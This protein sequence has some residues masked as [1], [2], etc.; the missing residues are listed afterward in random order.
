MIFSSKTVREFANELNI[1]LNQVL[2]DLE[3]LEIYT[4]GAEIISHTSLEQLTEI[5]QTRAIRRQEFKDKILKQREDYDAL[6]LKPQNEK[7][8]GLKQQEEIKA[9]ILKQR[10]VAQAKVDEIKPPLQEWQI[11]RLKREEEVKANQLKRQ[12]KRQEEAEAIRVQNQKEEARKLG[13]LLNLESEAILLKNQEKAEAIRLK[14]EAL[15]L[16]LEARNKKVEAIVNFN[17]DNLY[18]IGEKEE[19]DKPNIMTYTLRCCL[20]E[21]DEIYT[22]VWD[23]EEALI[24]WKNANSVYDEHCAIDS[25]SFESLISKN[26]QIKWALLNPSPEM[27]D[28]EISES[29]GIDK[30]MLLSAYGVWPFIKYQFTA[31]GIIDYSLT[32]KLVLEIP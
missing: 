27:T 21:L 8:A 32:K 23:N 10:Q 15:R 12:L 3:T 5:Y 30:M 2:A 11:I 16:E 17:F 18:V 1:P 26:T 19:T 28:Y 9:D 29:M 7:E 4:T 20:N 22:S 6:K 14:Q 25:L 31:Q 13:Q 24:K